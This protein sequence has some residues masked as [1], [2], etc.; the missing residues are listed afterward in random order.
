MVFTSRI[1]EIAISLVVEHLVCCKIHSGV[2]ELKINGYVK[3]SLS[4]R[5][6]MFNNITIHY[7]IID[8][9]IIVTVN[10]DNNQPSPQNIRASI[11]PIMYN[12]F[13]P[14]MLMQ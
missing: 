4:I 5:K 1:F 9:I 12:S 14:S 8:Y 6:I 7:Y 10:P 13:Q 3:I 2:K 11:S